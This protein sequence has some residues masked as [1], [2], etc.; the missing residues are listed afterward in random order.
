[1]FAISS[2][3]LSY[4]RPV[5]CKKSKKY[6]ERFPRKTPTNRRTDGGRTA[7]NLKSQPPKSVGPTINEGLARSNSLDRLVSLWYNPKGDN[8]SNWSVSTKTQVLHK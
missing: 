4:Y 7:V 2:L 8:L 3:F 6:Y 1:M 5:S